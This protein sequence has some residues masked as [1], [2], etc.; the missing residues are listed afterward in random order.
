MVSIHLGQLGCVPFVPV[1]PL[2]WHTRALPCPTNTS[3]LLMGSFD[4]VST[5]LGV[6]HVRQQQEY[7]DSEEADDVVA[8][9]SPQRHTSLTAITGT[10]AHA[11]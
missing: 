11:G 6:L 7:L 10:L 1:L 5:P 4:L 3:F 9:L 8:V 2:R